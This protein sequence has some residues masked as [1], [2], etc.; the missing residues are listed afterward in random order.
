MIGSARLCSAPS[1][2]RPGFY[3][4]AHFADEATE[5]QRGFVMIRFISEGRMVLEIQPRAGQL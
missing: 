4:Y 2:M 5:A 1:P 3:C